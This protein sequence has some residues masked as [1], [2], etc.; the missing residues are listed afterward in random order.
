[1]ATPSRHCA[2][3]QRPGAVSDGIMARIAREGATI[4][5]RVRR[6]CWWLSAIIAV[7]L[8]APEMLVDTMPAWWEPAA[9]LTLTAVMGVAISGWALVIAHSLRH[10]PGL[11]L[12]LVVTVPLL[13]TLGA[14]RDSR[15][16][17]S[18]TFGVDPGVFP[19]T[20]D[21]LT[22][23][24][25]L[26]LIFAFVALLLLA[27]FIA[28]LL[29]QIFNGGWRHTMATALPLALPLAATIAAPLAGGL[30]LHTH[31]ERLARMVDAFPASRCTY[32]DQTVAPDRIVF[33]SDDQVLAW[34]I[35]RARPVVL[36][37][38]LGD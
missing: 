14:R 5:R 21:V 19:V 16:T 35:D 33:L 34:R 9:L 7:T 36:E 38:R 15:L 2:D 17:L 30:T 27:V 1:M 22:A 3:N 37:C 10:W 32:P 20:L 29:L 6:D 23:L 13:T 31:V 11:L 25:T 24:H 18:Q 28:T 8:F 26:W 4:L 12:A